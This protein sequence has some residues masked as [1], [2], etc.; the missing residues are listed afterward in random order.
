MRLS[1]DRDHAR[2]PQHGARRDGVDRHLA[3]QARSQNVA[4]VVY[5][6]VEITQQRACTLL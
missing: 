4:G 2:A 5:V 1:D 6:S 3:S